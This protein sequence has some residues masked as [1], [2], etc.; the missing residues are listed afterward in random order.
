MSRPGCT[1]PVGCVTS[2][3]GSRRCSTEVSSRQPIGPPPRRRVCPAGCPGPGDALCAAT[4]RIGHHG[5]TVRAPFDGRGAN[6]PWLCEIP[7]PLSRVAWQ[8]PLWLHPD[9]AR[10]KGVEPA[11]ILRVETR[12]GS[13]EA[14]AYVTEVV[15]PGLALVSIG[16]GHASYGRTAQNAGAN[17]FAVL[18]A[19]VDP[20]CGG[21]SFTAFD[22]R[23]EKTRPQRKT[24]PYGRQPHSAPAARS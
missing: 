4:A 22:A 8:S 17:P 21:P 3:S 15:H 6:K 19:G 7:D 13:L 5:R 1:G 24:R 20:A 10:A 12:W 16:Q 18:P 11:D 2:S 9:T 23:I 14:P